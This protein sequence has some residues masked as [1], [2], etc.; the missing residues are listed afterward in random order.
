MVQQTSEEMRQLP[1]RQRF[2]P[3]Q[4][5]VLVYLRQSSK[6]THL[7]LLLGAR[8][9]LTFAVFELFLF[10]TR[11]PSGSPHLPLSASASAGQV[12]GGGHYHEIFILLHFAL[13][14]LFSWSL[15]YRRSG[16]KL[17]TQK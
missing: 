17:M 7:A 6:A 12:F 4:S 8:S 16:P 1:R 9:D 10:L 11:L 14:G 5:S 13:L 2:P 3:P 15:G